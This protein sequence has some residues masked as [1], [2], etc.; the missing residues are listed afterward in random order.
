MRISDIER[1]EVRLGRLVEFTLS[2]ATVAAAAALPEDARPPAY[3]QESHIRTARSVSDDGLSVPTWLGAAFDIPEQV[4]LDVLQGALQ[5]WTLRHETL[6]SGFRWTGPGGDELRRFTLDADEVSLH[7]TELGDFTDPAE[8]VRCLRERFDAGANALGWPNFVYAAVVR[9]DSTSVYTAF[10]HS[11]VD[12]YSLQR[13]PAEI[14][15][16]YAAGGAGRDAGCAPP[17]SYVDF[18]ELERADAD[19]IDGAH[20]I[21][22]RWREFIRRCDG[23]LPAFPLDLGLEPGAGLPTQRLAREMLVDADTAAAFETYCRPYGGSLVGV[24]AATSMIVQ[25]IGGASVYRTVVPFH[26]RTKSR[27][28]DSVGWYVGGAPIEVPLT[29]TLDFPGAL[30]AVRDELRANRALARLPLARVLRLLGTDFRPTSPD[31]YS[32][33]SFIDARGLPGSELWTEWN[34]YGL[35]RVSY[36]DQV[37]A[38]VNRLHE[39]LWF[40]SRHPDTEI[41]GKNMRLY[42]ERLRDI[43]ISA[44]RRP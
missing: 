17:G 42:T 20:A 35:V 36:G 24:L 1:C 10:D 30:A 39:G 33:V 28:S 13:L 16:L 3:I 37:C 6:R 2:P 34:A 14:N 5:A 44:A 19:R 40:A 26:T 7:R 22:S 8:L 21:V 29:P 25:E 12:A 43:V 23:R 4:D 41:A 31:L 11:N 18:C 38:W 32:I 15:E 9:P 27:W